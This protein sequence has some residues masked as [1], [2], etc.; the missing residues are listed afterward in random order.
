M[1]KKLLGIL[2]FSLLLNTDAFAKEYM[3]YDCTGHSSICDDKFVMKFNLKVNANGNIFISKHNLL[4][5]Q[6][7]VKVNG[8]DNFKI[9]S[10]FYVKFYVIN[11][12][13]KK[14]LF[15]I[16]GKYNDNNLS[17]INLEV[18]LDNAKLAKM[19]LK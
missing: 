2:V 17:L 8:F 13:N 10:K 16:N 5:H 14:F 7:V 12:L 11:N 18:E 6:H 3:A 15:I 4:E 1:I 19:K 9:N